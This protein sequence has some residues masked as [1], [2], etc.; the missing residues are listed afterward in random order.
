[1][2]YH[3]GRKHPEATLENLQMGGQNRNGTQRKNVVS[4]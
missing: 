2:P 1:M 3:F 4:M